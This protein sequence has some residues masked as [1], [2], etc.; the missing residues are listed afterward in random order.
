MQIANNGVQTLCNK[1]KDFF[2]NAFGINSPSTW[3]R[4]LGQWFAPGLINGLNG[5]ASIAKLN[6]GT[7]VFGE[8][9]KSG[10]SGTFDGLNSWMFNKGSDAAS[11]FYNGLSAAKNVRTGSKDDW[12]DEWYEK[13]IS[14][15][16][17]VTPNT[18][19]DDAAED[20]LGTLFGSGD[21]SP[22]GSGGTTTGKTKKSSGSG[23]KK[24]VAQQ[25]EEKYKPK[26]EA[27]KAAR[28]A[29]DSEYEL[30]QVENQYSADEDTLLSKKMENAAA[31]IANQTDRVAIA[32]AKYDEMLKRW[33][34]DKTETKE[35][36]ASLLSEKTSL[37]KLQADQYTGLFE[38]ITKRY[39]T[40]LGTLEKEYNLWTAQNSNTASKLDKIDRETEYQKDELE[41]KQK[42]EAKA[43][44]QWET[45]RKEY[46]ESDLRT[47]EAWNDYEGD[48]RALGAARYR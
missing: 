20:I 21:T 26:L 14:K 38:D 36:Y 44:E 37:A 47:K 13:E 30:W 15:Y 29:L 34:A 7:R 42:K 28:E 45:L 40:D 35:A 9:V 12:F 25:I 19:A 46:G 8:N 2:R 1:V 31:E 23:T 41:L 39:D 4:E 33:G 10:L 6:A 43:K 48:V 16:R 27:N 11:S 17:N 22:T 32:Q 3:M 18:V 24:T 5:T